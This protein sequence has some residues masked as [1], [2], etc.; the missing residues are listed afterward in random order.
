LQLGATY[1][2]ALGQLWGAVGFETGHTN[3]PAIE[4]STDQWRFAS[5]LSAGLRFWTGPIIWMPGASIEVSVLRQTDTRAA[6]STIDRSY[7]AL[8]E[9]DVLG[10]ST[11][12]TLWAEAPIAGPLFASADLTVW[13]RA[14]SAEGQS[15]WTIAPELE[16]ALGVRF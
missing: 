2:L 9:R 15:P 3:F 10:F 8:P 4:L 12:P 5:R 7:P 16:L 1:R 6:E 14:L 13:F 11:G